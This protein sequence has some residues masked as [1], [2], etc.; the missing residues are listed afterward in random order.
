MQGVLPKWHWTVP[1]LDGHGPTAL[2]SAPPAGPRAAA[3]AGCEGEPLTG[4]REED[5]RPVG[6]T[7]FKSDGTRATCPVGSTPTLFRHHPR[8]ELP[9]A[10]PYRPA[11]AA[12]PERDVR[13]AR[14]RCHRRR[15][16][17]RRPQPRGGAQTVRDAPDP[18]GA[19]HPDLARPADPLLRHVAGSRRRPLPSRAGAH[20]PPEALPL[21]E[22]PGDTRPGDRARPRPAAGLPGR[23]APDR[24]RS[25]LPRRRL[26][27]DPA[28][29]R[30]REGAR[31]RHQAGRRLPGTLGRGR[32]RLP[33]KGRPASGLRDRRRRRGGGAR[34]LPSLPAPDP[35]RAGRGAG[36]DGD[37]P[38]RGDPRGRR[39]PCPG[40]PPPDGPAPRRAG[41]APP[42]RPPGGG[43]AG[44]P[45]RGGVR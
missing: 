27:A 14:A 32:A 15:A 22:R 5:R 21:R 16:G 44:G 37:H 17:G 35:P 24:L 34:A 31:S 3:R 23:A 20:R 19:A 36:Q 29:Y 33:G 25:P 30:R 40:G 41:R 39:I 4:R 11:H 1:A 38:D 9:R 18:G 7:D 13:P 45:D 8:P 26:A 6:R 2:S 28:P 10:R 42:P 43:G 12:Q